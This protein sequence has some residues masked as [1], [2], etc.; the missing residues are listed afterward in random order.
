MRRHG[1]LAPHAGSAFANL[2]HE[3][4]GRGAV[5]LVLARDVDVRRSDR[6]TI[7]LMAGEAV[8]G[9]D[10]APPLIDGICGESVLQVLRA[11]VH[12]ARRDAAAA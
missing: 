9:F 6:F 4:R 11:H 7:Q 3:T 12:A 1:H 2:L 10:Q 8:V 5:V